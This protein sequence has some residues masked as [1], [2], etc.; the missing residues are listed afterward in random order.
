MSNNKF[1]QITENKVEKSLRN[2]KEFAKALSRASKGEFDEE[3]DCATNMD[4]LKVTELWTIRKQFCLDE[5]KHFYKLYKEVFYIENPHKYYFETVNPTV[6]RRIAAQKEH[7][8]KDWADAVAK[9]LG[10]AIIDEAAEA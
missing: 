6:Y 4:L 9:E 3:L 10:I 7:G 2:T 1:Q 8:D 5:G